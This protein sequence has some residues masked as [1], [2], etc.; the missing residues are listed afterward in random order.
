[1]TDIILEEGG[2]LDKYRRA[3]IAFWNRR[4]PNRTTRCAVR[5]R[6]LPAQWNDGRVRAANR[7]VLVRIGLNRRGGGGHGLDSR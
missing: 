4:L 1:M 7:A 2:T 3:I 6:A 5:C